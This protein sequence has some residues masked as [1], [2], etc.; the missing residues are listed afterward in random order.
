MEAPEATG[1]VE[2]SRCVR[3]C[4]SKWSLLEK[5]LAID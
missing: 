5:S 1:R 4:R 2:A 3:R